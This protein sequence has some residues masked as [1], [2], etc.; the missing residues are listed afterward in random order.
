VS[1][2]TVHRPLQWAC[3][4]PLNPDGSLSIQL[5]QANDPRWR[6]GV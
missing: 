4:Q 6:K 2:A 3:A 1:K 5:I